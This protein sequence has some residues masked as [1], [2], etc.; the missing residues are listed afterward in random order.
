MDL[1]SAVDQGNLGD[2]EKGAAGP[3][4]EGHCDFK[5][6]PKQRAAMIFLAIFER[7]QGMLQAL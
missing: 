1:Y 5:S 2:M 4:A 7:R 6:R 3:S